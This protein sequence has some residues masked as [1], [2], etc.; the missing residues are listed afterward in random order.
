MKTKPIIQNQVVAHTGNEE[1]FYANG[2]PK[3]PITED[4]FAEPA[5][6]NDTTAGNLSSTVDLLKYVSVGS[7]NSIELT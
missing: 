6:L 4:L 1:N 2:K 5:Q 7:N 3:N